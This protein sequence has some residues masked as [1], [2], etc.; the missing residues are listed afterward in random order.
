[1]GVI[2]KMKAG[3]FPRV[4]SASLQDVSASHTLRC[5]AKQSE[6]RFQTF[7]AWIESVSCWRLGDYLPSPIIKGTQPQYVEA[8][9]GSGIPVISTLAIQ[10]LAID[11]A[12]CRPVANGDYGDNE[13]RKPRRG[14]VLLTVDGGPSIGK[15]A[16][17]DLAGEWAIDS[18][19]A[20]LRPVGVDPELL[21]YLLASPI[22]QIQFEQ[23]E[24]GA[25]GQTSVT[26]EDLRRFRFPDI[27]KAKARQALSRVRKAIAEGDR[28]RRQ[29]EQ[30]QVEGWERFMALYTADM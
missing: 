19:V 24:S 7:K 6:Q 23:A 27:S 30:R 8:T 11:K 9:D 29:A 21:V 14:D 18:H 5:D 12:A 25:S 13:T 4:M 17:F 1:M 15:P 20:I 2:D 22:G 26:E 10:E 28:L 16:L 3:P